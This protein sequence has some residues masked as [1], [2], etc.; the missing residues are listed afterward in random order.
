MTKM[1]FQEDGRMDGKWKMENN[2]ILDALHAHLV[3][4]LTPCIDLFR[5][6]T[7]EQGHAIAMPFRPRQRRQYFSVM[8][9]LPMRQG[10]DIP[11]AFPAVKTNM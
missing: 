9:I 7:G 11:S 4:I 1:V 10:H 6:G 3:K 8:W 5:G 2:V